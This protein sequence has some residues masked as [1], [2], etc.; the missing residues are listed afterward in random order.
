MSAILLL[1]VRILIAAGLYAFLAWAFWTLY[2]DL[3]YQSRTL[4][5]Q[6][7]PKLSLW[8]SNEPAPRTYQQLEINIG[9]NAS[10]DL[11]LAD[12]TVSG[13]HARILYRQG[14][15]WL[16]DLDSTNGTYLNQMRLNEPMVLTIGDEIRCGQVRMDIENL[17]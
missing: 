12:T 2:Q 5:L 16:E 9:R 10:C 1:V 3:L 4:S 11:C 13:H 14:Q 6:A 7:L 15:W 8:V 17:S